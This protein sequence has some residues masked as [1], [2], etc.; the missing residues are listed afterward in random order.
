MR[1]RS[2]WMSHIYKELVRAGNGENAVGRCPPAVTFCLLMASLFFLAGC[3]QK[4]TVTYIPPE[5][6]R[7][8][9]Q[10]KAGPVAGTTR[11]ATGKKGSVTDPLSPLSPKDNEIAE[12]ATRL[13]K[14]LAGWRG[15]PYRMGGLSKKGVDC[16]G[17]VQLT[18]RDLFGRK[19]PR[20]VKD[21]VDYGK[22]IPTQAARPG[23]LVFFKTGL[24]QRH[25]GIYLEDGFFIH[26]SRSSGVILS[27]LSES[28]WQDNYW[29]TR[30]LLN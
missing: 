19:L 24:F 27:N 10:Q 9:V 16:S 30:R 4:V 12:T 8:S 14:H 3:F 13:K 17:F 25:V 1:T 7:P 6:R 15:T 18:Y 23:D 2:G 26:A 11:K 28:Y 21:Q 22:E 5:K 29:K 20:T